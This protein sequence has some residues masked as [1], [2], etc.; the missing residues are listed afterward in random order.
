MGKKIYSVVLAFFFC[1]MAV[2]LNAANYN[3]KSNDAIPL[4]KDVRTGVLPNGF[5]YFIMKNAKPE[6]HAHL[7]IVVNAGSIN[8]DDDQDGLAHFTEHMCFNGTKNYPGNKLLDVLQKFGIRFGGDVNASTGLDVTMYELPIPI[9]N[10]NL[11]KEGFQIL[12]DW[13]HNVTMEDDDIENERGIIMSEW[14]TRNNA[15]SR[16]HYAHMPVY[17]GNSQYAKRT[18]IGDTS[19][20]QNFKPPVIRRFYKDWYRPDLM[21]FIAVGDFDVDKIEKM[22]KEHFGNATNPANARKREIYDVPFNKEIRVSVVKDI[23]LPYEEVRVL[24]RFDRMDVNTYKGYAESLRQQL[25]SMMLGERLQDLAQDPN[26]PPFIAAGAYESNEVGNKSSF[27][28]IVR[29]KNGGLERGYKSLLTE[30]NRAKQHGF[31]IAEFERAKAN[32]IAM[33]DNIKAQKAS[34]EHS[35]YVD[36]LTNYFMG[37]GSMGGTD[38][39]VDYGKQLL[40]EIGIIEVNAVGNRYLTDENTIILVSLPDKADATRMT[41]DQALDIFKKTMAEKIDAKVEEVALKPLFDK[42]IK[43]GK[44]TN[45]VKDDKLGLET[46]TLSNGAKVVLK[47]TDFKENQILFGGQSFGGTS[48]YDD[49]DFYSASVAD[50]AGQIGGVSDFNQIDLGKVLTGK[51]IGLQLAVNE[52]TEKIQGQSNIKDL[53]TMFQLLYL[54]TTSPRLDKPAFNAWLDKVKPQIKAQGETQ[55]GAFRD[56][57]NWITADHHFRKQPT[58]VKFL[59]NVDYER[60]FEI[61]K[62]R[63]S[64]ANDFTYYIVG[65]FDIDQVKGFCEK[66]IAT[67]PAGKTENF[68]DRKT[69]YLKKPVDVRFRKGEADR[70]LVRLVIP[71]K[72]EYTQQNRQRLNAVA[73]VLELKLLEII[74]E[75]LSGTYSPSIWLSMS[76]YPTP[77]YAFNIHLVLDPKRVDEIVGVCKQI[78][79]DYIASADEV[80]ADKIK[81]ADAAQRVLDLKDNGYWLSTLMSYDQNGEAYS[82][83]MNWDKLIDSINAKDLQKYAKKYIDVNNMSVIVA[84]PGK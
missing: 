69:G 20:I 17:Y 52:L 31:S 44:I 2:S 60:A 41:K 77:Q 5:K 72:I 24:T 11:L 48:V 43:P 12:E 23:E 22:T 70:A 74:R 71:G 1:V 61:F 59:E 82:T 66:Y 50:N 57:V 38:F 54:Y 58:N 55:E 45:T 3:S 73:D 15:Q 80:G 32:Y 53:E 67:L 28:A 19:V 75:K 83:I 40:N 64:N 51:S 68:V 26:D 18:G 42:E 4:S 49:I 35:G 36:E 76:K 81:K 63:F 79:K 21:C 56:S 33:L 46:I 14:R 9:D 30:V 8:E 84:L 10:E 34:A 47:K 27:N 39:D 62:E 6:K 7:R 29:A 65:D 25:F 16:V 78:I 37:E 13:A